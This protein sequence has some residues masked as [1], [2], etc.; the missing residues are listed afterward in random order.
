LDQANSE[1]LKDVCDTF[2]I[3]KNIPEAGADDSDGSDSEPSVD[4]F[5]LDELKKLMPTKAKWQSKN[6]K[7]IKFREKEK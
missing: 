6:V 4:N 7:R 1:I 5:D 2:F 3:T